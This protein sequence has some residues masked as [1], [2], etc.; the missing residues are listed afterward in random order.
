MSQQLSVRCTISLDVPVGELVHEL[1]NP[2]TGMSVSVQVLERHLAQHMPQIDG[3]IVSTLQI[4]K[5]EIARLQLLLD[6]FRC[7]SGP[8]LLNLQPVALARVVEELVE[9]VV[10]QGRQ[11]RP[12]AKSSV[13][14]AL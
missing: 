4:L 14:A 5:D 10:G 7:V 1:A 8:V 2:L 11:E 12:P 6:E 3:T 9:N 13:L